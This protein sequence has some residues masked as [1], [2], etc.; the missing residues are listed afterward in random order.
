MQPD[1]AAEILP[2]LRQKASIEDM[3]LERPIGG[4]I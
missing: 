1:A 2:P 3:A 4:K